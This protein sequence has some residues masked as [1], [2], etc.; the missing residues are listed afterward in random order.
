MPAFASPHGHVRAK[1]CWVVGSYAGIKF[2][3]GRGRGP[4]FEGLF[5]LVLKALHDPELPVCHVLQ[6]RQLKRLQIGSCLLP[7]CC[8]CAG[9]WSA[10]L[11]SQ[12]LAHLPARR[13]QRTAGTAGC[14]V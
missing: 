12:A 14:C 6:P 10:C 7:S 13:Q 4:V 9:A 1:A 2:A 3:A 8:C 5:A 11:H